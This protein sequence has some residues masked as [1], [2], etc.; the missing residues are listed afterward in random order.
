MA[1]AQT[2]AF[3][4]QGDRLRSATVS[5]AGN[6]P[7]RHH[8]Y[9]YDAADNRVTEQ[10]GAAVSTAF[11][12]GLNQVERA[13][14]GGMMRLSGAD[15]KPAV[16]RIGGNLAEQESGNQFS[17]Y[18]Q[19][20]PGL[21]SLPTTATDSDGNTRTGNIQMTVTDWRRCD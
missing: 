4:Y 10:D 19:V 2:Y 14:G 5:G 12:D 21:N 13:A 11:V 18:G 9:G 15:D 7:L 1:Q 6:S 16:V 3:A 20:V 8:E 17:G